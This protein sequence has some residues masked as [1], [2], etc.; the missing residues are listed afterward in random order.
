MSSVYITLRQV[1]DREAQTESAL[2]RSGLTH[3]GR[4]DHLP[5][6]RQVLEDVAPQEQY[7]QYPILPII[8]YYQQNTTRNLRR[9][10]PAYARK[11]RTG[12]EE[13]AP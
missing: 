11:L 8:K 13:V 6:G 3:A 10:K 9:V 7:Y 4:A 1:F 5:A 12:K 2:V